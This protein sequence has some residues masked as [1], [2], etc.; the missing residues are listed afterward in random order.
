ML[1]IRTI[2]DVIHLLNGLPESKYI[3]QSMFSKSINTY[4]IVRPGIVSKKRKLPSCIIRPSYACGFLRKLPQKSP[5]VEIKS[6]GQIKKMKN[7]C[8]IAR[9]ILLETGYFKK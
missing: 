9:D 1:S 5:N 7:V 3:I 6:E 2:N 8:A 4:A